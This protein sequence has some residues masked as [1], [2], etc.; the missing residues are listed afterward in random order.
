M[1]F[2]EEELAELKGVVLDPASDDQTFNEALTR[3]RALK[4]L[5][6]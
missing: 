4:E 3:L 2:S 1:E 6:Q 5:A